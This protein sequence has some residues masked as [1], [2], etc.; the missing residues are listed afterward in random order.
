MLDII[1]ILLI[2]ILY[3]ILNAENIDYLIEIKFKILHY[4]H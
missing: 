1:M 2:Q 3:Y 4:Y